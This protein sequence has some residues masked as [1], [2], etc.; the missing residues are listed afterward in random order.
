M[1][2]QKN[3]RKLSVISLAMFTKQQFRINYV[4]KMSIKKDAKKIKYYRMPKKLL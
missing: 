1:T 2:Y 3:Y 4:E